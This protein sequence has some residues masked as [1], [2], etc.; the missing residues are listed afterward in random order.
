MT[1]KEFTKTK[2]FKRFLWTTANSLM[3]L[4]VAYLTFLASDNVSWAIA[5]LPILTALSQSLTKYL[6]K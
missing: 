1:L 6:N 5:V 3:G 4:F 2:E